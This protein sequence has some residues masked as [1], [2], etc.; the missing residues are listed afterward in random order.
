MEFREAARFV[1]EE[2]RLEPVISAVPPWT[3]YDAAFRTMNE[4]AQFSK[5]VL[6]VD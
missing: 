5:L 1:A 2:Q 6:T 4:G 3:E